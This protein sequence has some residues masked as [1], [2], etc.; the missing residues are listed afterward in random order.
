MIFDAVYV[1][2][3]CA[4]FFMLGRAWGRRPWRALAAA[5][6][7]TIDRMMALLREYKDRNDWLMAGLRGP[8][9]DTRQDAASTAAAKWDAGSG[10]N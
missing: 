8:G 9:G 4:A 10:R 1:S 6:Y 7:E 3:M 5:Q 2:A